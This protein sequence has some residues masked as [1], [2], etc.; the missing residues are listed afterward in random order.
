[1]MPLQRPQRLA[2]CFSADSIAEQLKIPHLLRPYHVFEREV[3]HRRYKVPRRLKSYDNGS[4][5]FLRGGKEYCIEVTG[6]PPLPWSN[7][8]VG[9]SLGCIISAGGGGYMRGQ[10]LCRLRLMPFRNDALTGTYREK[11]IIRNDRT[12]HASVSVPEQACR[13]KSIGDI[14][15]RLYVI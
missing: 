10:C 1:M 11:V 2:L 8:L 15:L 5:G 9:M 4:G 14:W 6:C 7:L 13:W 3:P 12:G